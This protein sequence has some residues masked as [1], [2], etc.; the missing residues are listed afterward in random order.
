M[1]EVFS[2]LFICWG[3]AWILPRTPERWKMEK[4]YHIW[5]QQKFVFFVLIVILI[6][7]AGL[8]TIMNDTRAYMASFQNVP[9]S[10]RAIAEVDWTLGYNPGFQIYQIILKRLGFTNGSVFLVANAA[11]VSTSYVLFL[12]NH[13]PDF[14]FSIY[15]LIASTTYAFTMAAIK[16]TIA[17]AIG[18]WAIDALLKHK[19]LKFVLLILFASTFHPY[20]LIFLIAPIFLKGVWSKQA[21]LTVVLA[22]IL[23]TVFGDFV[24][25]AI[26]VTEAIG[27]HYEMGFFGGEGVNPLR[28]LVYA[29]TPVL[30][31]L[32]KDN[33]QKQKN[34]LIDLLVNFSIVSF[35]FMILA[36]FGGANIFGRM[37]N[38]FDVLN[39]VA[40]PL[41]LHYGMYKGEAQ[42]MRWVAI[43][44]YV[45]F[46]YTYFAKYGA[47]L[48]ADYYQ[49]ISLIR[50]F[51]ILFFGG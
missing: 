25:T 32:C 23:G 29:V 7:F 17:M 13:S 11:F 50:F 27:D 16:Q 51:K 46:Y 37:A 39:C 47:Y 10:L 3:L 2:L 44:C 38:Y 45:M 26:F 15:L 21:V 43:P 12:R 30:A 19:R 40:L 49:H 6:F 24:E 42:A 31:F 35:C 5:L 8:R 22:V 20:I 18:I 1:L 41:V 9:N 28:L 33:L 36:S 14:S 34:P 48:R 4:P